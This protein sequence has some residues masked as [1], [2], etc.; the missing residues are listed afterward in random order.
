MRTFA[1]PGYLLNL[2]S[3]QKKGQSNGIYSICS[4]NQSVL[5]ACILVSKENENSQLLVE[6]TC[7]QVNQFGGYTGLTP[8][9]F[10]EFTASLAD[11]M[12]YPQDRILLGGD[13]LGPYPWRNEPAEQAMVKACQMVKDYVQAGYRKIH[14]DASMP[15]IDDAKNVP[16]SKQISAE[17]A[18]QLC[19][20]AENAQ[21]GTDTDQQPVYVIGTEV[22]V[23]GG[24]QNQSETIQI[25]T[26]D[27]ILETLA[28]FQSTFANHGLESA[29]ERVIALV[30]Q[31]GVEFN[32]NHIIEYRREI[33]I[34]ISRL[35]EK[36]PHVVFEA[37]ST[38]YQMKESLR[39]MVEDHFAVLKVGPAL[40]FAFREAVFA[41][42]HIEQ[43][44]LSGRKGIKLSNLR[45]VI[46][47]AMDEETKYW[48][49]Y[50]TGDPREIEIARM[51]SYSDRIRYYWNVPAVRQSLSSLIRNLEQEIIPLSLLS[52][53]LP[54]QYQHVRSGQLFQNPRELIWDHIREI[55]EHYIYAC[56][57]N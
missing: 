41:L 14:I 8:Y 21:I 50:V 13:H 36:L 38:D 53:Y 15:C 24:Q 6:S 18:V 26:V 51:Y 27:D 47:A 35:V 28:I 55:I 30:V 22:P 45:Q 12:N 31:P 33:T 44:W 34:E 19:E 29:W 1:S 2:V 42:T 11:D 3:Q 48:Q 57:V 56:N 46:N 5:E 10:A 49:D 43:E 25:T 39:R 4:A 16:L 54:V 20:M 7:N 52:Q 37:H 40:T 17:R 23:P 9:H 32:E